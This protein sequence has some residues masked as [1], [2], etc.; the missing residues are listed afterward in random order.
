MRAL[1]AWLW[2]DGS[3]IGPLRVLLVLSILGPSALFAV[4]AI[5]TYRAA[6]HD[7]DPHAGA[8]QRSSARACQQGVRHP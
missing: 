3:A 7:A 5:V 2:R 4:A 8:H 6:F 1:L